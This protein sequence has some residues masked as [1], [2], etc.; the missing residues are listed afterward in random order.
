MQKSWSHSTQS[1]P[2]WQSVLM[3]GLCLGLHAVVVNVIVN[4]S[5]FIERRP[6]W[7]KAPVQIQILTEP[8]L[9]GVEATRP[10]SKPVEV[11]GKPAS[12]TAN[13]PIYRPRPARPVQATAPVVPAVGPGVVSETG[14]RDAAS[15]SAVPADSALPDSS[16]P[17]VGSSSSAGSNTQGSVNSADSATTGATSGAS[18]GATGGSSDANAAA[19]AD[20]PGPAEAAG[21]SDSG[22]LLIGKALPAPPPSGRWSYSIH[23]GDFDQTGSAALLKLGFENHGTAYSLRAEISATGLT[24]L[25]YGGVRKDFSRGRITANGFEPERYAELRSKGA[26]RAT[27]IDYSRKQIQF[28]GGETA[29]FPEGT[30]DRLSSL[31]QLGLLARAQPE[32]FVAGKMVEIPE[33]NLRDVENIRY[34]IDG[35]GELKTRLGVLRTLHLTRQPG[36]SGKDPEIE[37][38]LDYDF[39]MMP[40]RIR[41]TDASGR[42][43]DQVI[44]SK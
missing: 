9:R 11:P 25:F 34:K 2:F 38:W 43:I 27:Q 15:G 12:K 37:L 22:R 7:R 5:A 35:P 42:V 10:D 13:K 30:Q 41:V 28:A 14:S 3:I 16:G 1:R 24:A 21:S 44:D 39:G 17:D 31:F 8:E 36:A 29:G 18:G 6:D 4:Q 26:E 33:M 32:L 23:L 40:V 19:P 20:R